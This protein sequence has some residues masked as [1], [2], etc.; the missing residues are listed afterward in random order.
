MCNLACGWCDTKYTWDGDGFDLATELRTMTFHRVARELAA[1]AAPM[2]V[3]TGGEPALQRQGCL[4]L[5]ESLPGSLHVEV[6]TSGTVSMGQLAAQVER[7]V[8]SPKL[9]HSGQ[10]EAARLR[11]HVLEELATCS[12]TVFK[13]V[14]RDATDLDEVALIVANLGVESCRVWVMPEATTAETLLLRQAHLAGPV[15][16]R[17]WNLSSRLQILLWGDKRGH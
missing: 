8:V 10:R 4:R 7:V 14:V 3:I 6:E 2:L 5:L 15:A 9:S 12:N 11:W 16:D 17:G 1:I 13:F